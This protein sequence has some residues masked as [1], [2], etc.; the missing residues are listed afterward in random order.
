MK[1]V[2]QIAAIL[3]IILLV[4]MYVFT[5]IAA[6][7]DNPETMHILGASIALSIIVPVLIWVL[8][9]FVRIGKDDKEQNN[10]ASK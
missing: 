4:G 2:R 8:G 9:I 5:L 3:G 1:K 7:T 6:F 10:K